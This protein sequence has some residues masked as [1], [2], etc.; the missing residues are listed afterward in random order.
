MTTKLFFLCKIAILWDLFDNFNYYLSI[1]TYAIKMYG[2]LT[3]HNKK[4]WI[5]KDKVSQQKHVVLNMSGFNIGKVFLIRFLWL[6]HTISLQIIFVCEHQLHYLIQKS[7]Y[8]D[9]TG[10]SI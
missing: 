2:F 8:N 1:E 7:F 9:H 5:I 10:D 3:K 4:D 6:L